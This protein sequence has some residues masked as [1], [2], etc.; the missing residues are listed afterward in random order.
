MLLDTLLPAVCP[1]CGAPGR[2][3][4][5]ACAARLVPAPALRAPPGLDTLTA[6]YTYE[7]VARELVARVKYRN[8]RAVVPALAAAIAALHPAGSGAGVEEVITWPPTT[9][10]RR[11]ERGFDAAEVLARAVARR[12][13]VR[14]VP[15]LARE[16]GPPQTGRDP[17]GPRGGP[18]LSGRAHRA[19][20]R[21]PRRRRC[22]DGCDARGCGACVA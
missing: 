13:G 3:V 17:R 18:A 11:R 8:A 6:R 9:R 21:R 5:H 1:G 16:A 15:L 4:C 19:P 12:L 2:P 14:A 20:C 22:H 10:V 7:G